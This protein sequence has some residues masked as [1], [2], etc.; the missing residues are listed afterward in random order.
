LT[1]KESS[2]QLEQYFTDKYKNVAQNDYQHFTS[3][4]ADEVDQN[5][6]SNDQFTEENSLKNSNSRK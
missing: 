2:P 6:F 3:E 4:E 1:K 5:Y